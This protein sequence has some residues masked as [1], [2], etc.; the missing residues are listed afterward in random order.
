MNGF[1][2]WRWG[3][4]RVNTHSFMRCYNLRVGTWLLLHWHVG[5]RG[6]RYVRLRG[7]LLWRWASPTW[8]CAD[9]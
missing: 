6:W 5:G 1:R 3:A 4:L 2:E 9:W 7:A 8:L